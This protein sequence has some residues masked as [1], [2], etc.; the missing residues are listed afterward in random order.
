MNFQGGMLAGGG[1]VS[2]V[3]AAR[4]LEHRWRQ[5]ASDSDGRMVCGRAWE[6]R[7]GE[8]GGGERCGLWCFSRETEEHRRMKSIA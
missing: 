7:F 8:E 4:R 1:G 3:G 6:A 5:A 2:R